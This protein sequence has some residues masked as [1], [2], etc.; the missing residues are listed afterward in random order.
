[1]GEPL[2]DTL[3][4]VIVLSGAAACVILSRGDATHA[5]NSATRWHVVV[6]QV[7]LGFAVSLL[8]W[9]W[10]DSFWSVATAGKSASVWLSISLTAFCGIGIAGAVKALFGVTVH[11][12]HIG[13]LTTSGC[14]VAAMLLAQAWSVALAS[15]TL[16]TG[17]AF[18]ERWWPHG[19]APRHPSPFPGGEREPDTCGA[20]R[21]DN[22]IHEPMLLLVTGVGLLVLLLGTWQHVLDYEVQRKT[23]SQR[24]SAWTRPRALENAWERTDMLPRP[25][26]PQTPARSAQLR[27]REMATSA[28]LFALLLIVAG[29]GWRRVAVSDPDASSVRGAS[30]GS[31]QEVDHAG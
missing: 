17:A 16:L 2:F 12:R 27:A 26:D 28:G 25:T 22:R 31:T 14:G 20:S 5:N 19:T 11:S 1:M 7:L 21:P 4:A 9:R 29:Y 15:L 10:I 3:T 24:Y 18:A 8:L 30:C 6:G 13:F 23:R